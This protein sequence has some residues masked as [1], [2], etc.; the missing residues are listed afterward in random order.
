MGFRIFMLIVVLLI[1]LTMLFFGWLLFKRTPKEINY[2]FGYRTKRS[3]RDEETSGL[4]YKHMMDISE[5]LK[6]LQ[7][8]GKTIIVATHDGEFIESC[9]SRKLII[10]IIKKGISIFSDKH[11]IKKIAPSTEMISDFTMPESVT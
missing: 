3:M 10:W 6:E 1:P 9:C 7:S 4:D 5:I 8:M 2:V 11:D